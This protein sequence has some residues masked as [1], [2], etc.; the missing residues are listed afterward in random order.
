VAAAERPFRAVSESRVEMVEIMFPNDANPAGT[1]MGGRV[2][3][4]IDVAAAIAASRHA[5]TLCVTASVDH[6]DF[7]SPVRVG[8]L[9]ILKAS[10]N[11]VGTTS[12]EVGVRVEVEHRK[13]GERRHTSSA[14]LTF[15]A[16]DDDRKPMIVPE[17]RPE[18]ADD[19]RRFREAERRRHARLQKL[20]KEPV[21]GGGP[22]DA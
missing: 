5:R 4:L 15:V 19:L 1:V 7:R 14:Y 12:L 11:Y 20:G 10:V 22:A 18:T 21:P 13:T 9:L 17:L 2:M 6:I 3:H 8:E 16:L